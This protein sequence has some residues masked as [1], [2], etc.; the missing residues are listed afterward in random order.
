VEIDDAVREQGKFFVYIG[1]LSLV[2]TVFSSFVFD[3]SIFQQLLPLLLSAVVFG[4]PHGAVD[5]F[6]LAGK[7][8]SP[9]SLRSMLSVGSIYLFLGSLTLAIWFF[10]PVLAFLGFILITLYHW[11]SAESFHIN[12][13]LNSHYLDSSIQKALTVLVR[14]GAPMILPLVAFPE[15][16]LYVA[17]KLVGIFSTQGIGILQ[18]FFSSQV[19]FTLLTLYFVMVL[20]YLGNAYIK[21]SDLSA[22]KPDFFEILLLTIFFL[23]VPSILAIGI[24]FCFWHSLRHIYRYTLIDEDNRE[25]YRKGRILEPVKKFYKQAAPLTLL[26]ILFIALLHQTLQTTNTV[27][28]ITSTYLLIISILTP[29]HIAI[30]QL[31]QRS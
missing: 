2:F 19:R 25:S 6:M 30:A 11:G 24:Y 29:P 13:F 23:T 5:M 8:E 28:E 17:K 18:H 3:F 1:W 4:L 26:S 10:S 21:T 31:S 16:Y 22:L 12:S 14:G 20:A 9:F 15:Y 7:D 27:P